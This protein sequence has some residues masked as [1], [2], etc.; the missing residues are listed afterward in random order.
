MK[1]IL[2]TAGA[3]REYLDTVRFL[4]NASTGLMAR[5][6]AEKFLNAGFEVRIVAGSV[7][8]SFPE[9]CR[10]FPVETSDEMH[11]AAKRNFA[12]ADAAI[13]A[14]AVCDWKP[15]AEK[16]KIKKGG[17][18]LVEFFPTHDIAKDLS[19]AKGK[20]ITVGFALEDDLD[21]EKATAKM[22][23]KRFDYV[24]LNSR[25]AIASRTTSGFIVG[26]GEVFSFFSSSKKSLAGVLCAIVCKRI[27]SRN[28][29]GS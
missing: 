5:S 27:N 24:V 9:R 11:R 4:T 22:S 21:I 29:C 25:E 14:A 28:F 19:R 10:V 12:W 20:K 18:L 3:T 23:E 7:S 13:F 26:G 17:R 15:K 6:L 8:I 16:S 1:K 2:I